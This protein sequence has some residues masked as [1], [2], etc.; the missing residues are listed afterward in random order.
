MGDTYYPQTTDGRADWWQ[1]K[2]DNNAVIA[3]L[4][5]AAAPGILADA[6]D[7]VFLYR[8]LPGLYDGFTVEVHAYINA[9][10]GGAD[11]AAPPVAPPVPAWPALPAAGV[12]GGIE[13]RRA[14]WVQN[15]KNTPGYKPLA[16]G[17]TLELEAPASSF[18]AHTYQAQITSAESFSPA[19]V[20]AAFRKARGQVEGMH[21][22]GRKTGTT[23]WVVLGRFTGTPASL[24]I[25][26]ATP[27]QPEQW[28]LQG[29][30]VKRD[31]LI[32]L[33]SA[34]ITVLVRG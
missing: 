10:L 31:V 5:A 23:A 3:A 16:Q 8:T 30:A 32:G 20:L 9:Y 17:A 28:E 24:H 1:N 13:T 11:G 2:I 19:S 18:N 15:L 14:K 6:K 33:P 22:N 4:N 27:G 26:I 25:P 12:L 29:Q 21:F 7:A 34:I